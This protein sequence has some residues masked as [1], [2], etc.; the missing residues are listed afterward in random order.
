MTEIVD[1]I[2]QIELFRELEPEDKEKIADIS[3]LRQLYKKTPVFHE[4][5][6][7]ESVYFICEGLIKT[8]KTDVQGNEQIVNILREGDLFPHT[9]FFDQKPYPATAETLTDA[10]LIAIPLKSFEHMLITHPAI[11]IKVM[12]VMGEKLRELQVALQELTGQDVQHR[13]ISFLLKLARLHRHGED[14]TV[15]IELPITHQEIANLVGTRRETVNRVL[16]S[17]KKAELITV[18][19]QGILIADIEGLE[20]WSEA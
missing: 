19:R 4:G 7:K 20:Q 6:P 14:A 18:Q 2:D 13:I 9:G 5:S 17:L 1:Y 11:A 3:I 8:Y 10:R 15:H 16:N 12:R